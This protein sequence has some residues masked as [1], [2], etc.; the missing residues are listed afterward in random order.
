M[1]LILAFLAVQTEIS[2]DKLSLSGAFEKALL[3][4]ERLLQS[5][6]DIS[7]QRGLAKLS[8]TG[9]LPTLEGGGRISEQIGF[10]AGLRVPLINV[11]GVLATSSAFK[12]L[13][14]VEATYER[15]RDT[16]L[17]QVAEAYLSVLTEQQ[18]LEL[19][20]T[21]Y[22]TSKKQ[23]ESASRK[24]ALQEISTLDLKRAQLLAAKTQVD[25]SNREA[26]FQAALGLLADFLGENKKFRL[27]DFPEILA[28]EEQEVS[29]LIAQAKEHRFDLKAQSISIQAAFLGEQSAK[30]LFMPTLHFGTNLV[31]PLEKAHE[32]E[33]RFDISVPLFDG[34]A[35]YGLLETTRAKLRQE[36]FKKHLLER[37]IALQVQGAL[38]DIARRKQVYEIQQELVQISHAAHKSAENR[39]NLGQA[40]S[41]DLLD[42]Q[43]RLFEAQKDLREAKFL[44]QQSRLNL[45]YISGDPRLGIAKNG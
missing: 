41:L 18:L 19:S 25:I 37:E 1:F 4:N 12:Q 26:S 3:K 23:L 11:S 21:Q 44:L 20:K 24:A 13:K 38:V 14:S 6:E 31:Q 42:E 32:F 33:F 5:K 16:L 34:Y 22:E 40:T 28:L 30:W 43:T 10:S 29:K 15:Q 36:K 45:S 27:E 35:R 9:L 2:P 39:Y 17:L 7:A 8:L